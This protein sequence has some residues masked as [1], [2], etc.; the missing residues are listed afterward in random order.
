MCTKDSVM[1]FYLHLFLLQIFIE[2][3]PCIRCVPG[4]EDAELNYGTVC[5]LKP[6]DGKV[7]EHNIDDN[8]TSNTYR[9]YTMY[10]ALLHGLTHLMLTIK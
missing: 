2:G 10:L 7:H 4:L 3:L 6:R 1:L 5:V 9:I 8:N